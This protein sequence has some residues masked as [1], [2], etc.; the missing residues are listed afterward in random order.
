ML[1]TPAPAAGGDKDREREREKE[2]DA[3]TKGDR[4]SRG[5]TPPIDI[6]AV[7]VSTVPELR[8]VL[9]EPDRVVAASIAIS[10]NV[11]G[12]T[13]RS[14]S[15]PHNVTGGVLDLLYQLTRLP[16]NQ[17]AWKKELSDA[18]L[19]PNSSHHQFH[20]SKATGFR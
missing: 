5:K 18:S 20:S 15:F 6:V 9:V 13:F 4:A 2:N 12:P 17:K 14:K 8:K 16:N 11:I 19:I 10:T 7:L 3:D 1:E